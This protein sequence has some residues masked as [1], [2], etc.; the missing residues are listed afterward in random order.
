MSSRLIG[1]DPDA[2]KDWKQEEK[3]VAEDVMVGWHP[4]LNGHE[5]EQAPGED[6]GQEKPGMLQSMGLQRVRHDLVTEQQQNRNCGRQT[7]RFSQQIYPCYPIAFYK[8]FPERGLH[9]DRAVFQWRQHGRF[10]SKLA[11]ARTRYA[12]FIDSFLNWLIH[13]LVHSKVFTEYQKP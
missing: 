13:W 2:G 1:K 6:E 8:R 7:I 5:F 10:A 3:R 12:L 11:K 4:W 9:V